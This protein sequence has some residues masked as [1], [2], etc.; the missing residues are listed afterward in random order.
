MP[1]DHTYIEREEIMK[2]GETYPLLGR[3]I[4]DNT[5]LDWT[6]LMMYAVKTLVGVI[7]NLS[8]TFKAEREKTRKANAACLELR[9][10]KE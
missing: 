2:L 5:H 7:K 4:Q 1:E 8:D 3:L 9:E 10:S 6:H